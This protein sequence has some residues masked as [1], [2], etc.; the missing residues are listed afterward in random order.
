MGGGEK[1]RSLKRWERI[2][3]T[4]RRRLQLELEQ[5]PFSL[6]AWCS[7][8]SPPPRTPLAVSSF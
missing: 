8:S 2:L 7:N 5:L 4:R 6:D 3:R 1:K